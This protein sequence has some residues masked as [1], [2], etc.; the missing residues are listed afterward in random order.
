[1]YGFIITL[2]HLW[3]GRSNSQRCGTLFCCQLFF[4]K[5]LFAALLEDSS[6]LSSPSFQSP[7][8]SS[9]CLRFSCSLL[10]WRTHQNKKVQRPNRSMIQIGDLYADVIRRHLNHLLC[11]CL[12]VFP[13]GSGFWEC[14]IWVGIPITWRKYILDTGWIGYGHE[15]IE[16]VY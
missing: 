14:L 13:F 2:I 10:S 5:S 4:I 8:G 11:C 15:E 7:F 6:V 9:R 12:F 1:M 3:G 16:R